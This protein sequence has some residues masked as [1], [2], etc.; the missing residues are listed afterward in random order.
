MLVAFNKLLFT[1]SDYVSKSVD[2]TI[3]GTLAINSLTGFITVPTPINPNDAVNKSYVDSYGLWFKGT[4]GNAA[5]LYFNTGNVGM[6][7]ATPNVLG[8]SAGNRVLTISSDSSTANQRGI[9]ELVDSNLTGTSAPIASID[10]IGNT[11]RLVRLYGVADGAVDS[12]YFAIATTP[13]TG[14]NTERLRVTST[15]YVGIGTNSPQSKLDVNGAIRL[16]VDATACSGANAGAMR[17]ATPNVEYCNGTSWIAFGQS[18]AAVTSAQITDGSI[19]DADINATANISA[20]KLGTGI[21]DNTEFNYLDGVTSSIQTQMNNKQPLNATLTALAAYNTNGILV[22]TA[23]GT[24]SGRSIAG[25]ANRLTVS[26]GDGVA[27]NP[28]LNLNSTLLPSPLAGDAGKFLKTTAAD[29]S[30]WTALGLTDITTAL[31]YT[32]I[33]KAGDSISTGTFTLN[34]T[35]VLR[36]PDPIGV[37]DVANKQYVDGFGQWTKTGSD[38]YRSG[39]FVG[40]GTTGPGNLLQVETAGTGT[41]VNSNRIALF[42]SK[43]SGKDSHIAFG[44]S[45]NA[46][47]QIGYLSG[48]LYTATNG[49]ERMRID[50]NGNFGLGM[51]APVNKVDIVDTIIPS[52]LGFRYGV[53]VAG[54]YSILA[55]GTYYHKGIDSAVTK[56]IPSGITDGGYLAG[57]WMLSFRNAPTTTADNGT[58]TNLYGAD[59]QYGHYNGDVTATPATTNAY[60]I[61]IDP[62]YRTGTVTNMYDLFLSAETAGGMATNRW[63]IYQN[64]TKN[65]YFAG[66]IGIGVN[67][68]A[69]LLT[70]RTVHSPPSASAYSGALLIHDEQN[71]VAPH[72]DVGVAYDSGGNYGWLQVNNS[73]ASPGADGAYNLVLQGAGGNV[74]IG[75]TLPNAKLQVQGS[76][77]SSVS[78]DSFTDTPYIRLSQANTSGV[79]SQLL[80]TTS[81]YG[82]Y[83]I[84]SA[85]SLDYKLRFMDSRVGGTRDN[86]TRMLIDSSG[87]LGIGTTLPNDKLEVNGNVRAN[88]YS[89]YASNT[90]NSFETYR[91]NGGGIVAS[92]NQLGALTFFGHDGGAYR[93]AA[94]IYGE[95]DGTPAAGSMPGR[96]TFYTTPSGSTT[97][98]ENMRIEASGQVGI[99][100]TAPR[101]KLDVAGIIRA[102]STTAVGGSTL[103]VDAYTS[104]SL[105]N[106]GTEQSSGGP[107]IGYGVTPSTSSSGSFVSSTPLALTRTALVMSDSFR[108]YTGASQ[109]VA[110]ASAV[111]TSEVMRI[112]NTGKV[113]IGTSSP[114]ATLEIAPAAIAGVQE[115]LRITDSGPGS[116]EGGFISWYSNGKANQ[117]QIGQYSQTNGSDLLFATNSANTGNPTERIRIN[118]TGEVG[119]GMT[120]V[121]KLDV[122]GDLRISGT[123]YRTGGDIAWQTPSDRRLKNIWGDYKKGLDEILKL[124]TVEFS[125]KKNNPIGADATKKYSGVIAQDLQKVF[126][127]SVQKDKSGYLSINTTA[128]F[129]SIVN[130][131]K[132]IYSHYLTPML[133]RINR[134]EKNTHDNKRE[135]ASLKKE[136]YLLK[137]RTIRSEKRNA[138]LALAVCQMNPKASVCH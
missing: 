85:D 136:I 77:T 14:T 51:T 109:T 74:G 123:P 17:F 68:P 79:N 121:Y 60:G 10:L 113:G 31:G 128:I 92:G 41:T 110:T 27:G 117:A 120:A 73:A 64:N 65:N 8:W 89:G 69:S 26:N 137:L 133:E 4:G 59:I 2:Q 90:Y 19:I 62:Y 57:G 67:T 55:N 101:Q 33:N 58:L 122:S 7:T 71:N 22:Q 49:V 48:Q 32:P 1:Q 124:K 98:A 3:N 102:G 86:Q 108:F 9:L 135:I 107:V 34:G 134:T 15:G 45:F 25:T 91:S 39:G 23:A 61:K 54:S 96:L 50:T 81:G 76:T 36:T 75:T 37:T 63:G 53:G 100:T 40:I 12:G 118:S 6:G 47:A 125:Y 78:I 30:V 35:A 56:Q 82:S 80:F 129:W 115:A 29:T 99:G 93:G 20:S 16:G 119:I 130:A 42:Q 24:F 132:D 127:E 106:L 114:S 18:G 103:L 43:A 70:L 5:D 97:L 116:T 105:T 13:T 131:V 111:A 88:N 126:P 38:V 138:E 11:N 44:D 72:L 112:T 95:V 21:V 28:T 104:G 83:L 52:N 87:N 84:S 46:T 94:R 66:K